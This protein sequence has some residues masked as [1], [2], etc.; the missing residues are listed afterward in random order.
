VKTIHPGGGSER[1]GGP[2]RG[3]GREK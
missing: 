2:Y 1:T 3:M